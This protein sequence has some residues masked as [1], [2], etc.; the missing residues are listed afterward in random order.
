MVKRLRFCWTVVKRLVLIGTLLLMALAFWLHAGERSLNFA[1]P[2]IERA[3]NNPSAPYSISIGTVSVDWHNVAA[4]GKLRI[5][6][7]SF[8]KRDGSIFAKL[9]E[10]YATIDPIGFMPTRHLLHKVILRQ[11]SLYLVRN[12]DGVL[13]LGIENSPTRM[14]AAELESFLM[15]NDTPGDAKPMSLP[16]HDFIIEHANLTFSDEI[17]GTKIISSP[18]DFRLSRRR[19]SF[20]AVMAMP[21]TV[22]AVPVKLS[23]GL[24]ILPNS[25]S[26]VLSVQ[27]NGFPTKLICLFGVCDAGLNLDAAIS[28]NLAV[29]LA[30]DFS[31]HGFKASLVTNR[32]TLTAPTWFEQ[33]LALGKSDLT[34]EGDWAQQTFTVSQAN[35]TLEDTTIQ[36][37]ANAHKAE[38]GWYATLNGQTQK[39]DVTKLYKYWPLTMAPGSRTWVTSKMKS[40]YAAKGTLR[41]N[42]TPAEFAAEHFSDEAV[43]AMVDARQITFEYLPGFPLVERIDGIAHFTGT[44][45]KVEST[46]GSLLSGTTIN[47]AV[48]WVPDLNDP[49]IPMETTTQLTAPAAD[50][51]TML[52]LKHFPFDDALGLDPKAISGNVNATMKLKFNA[53]SGKPNSD[54]NEIHLDAVDYDIAASLTNVAQQRLYGSYDARDINAELNASNAGFEVKG[55]LVVGESG[56]HDFTLAQKSGDVLKATVKGRANPAPAAPAAVN[57]FSLVYE[58]GVVPTITVRGKRID[59]SMSYGKSENSLLANFPAMKLD[60]DVGELV[61]SSIESF[62]EVAGTLYCTAERCETADFTAKTD[63]GEVKATIGSLN[64]VRRFLLSA[65]DAGS[66]LKALDISE[67]MSKGVLELRGTYDDKKTPPQFNGRLIIKDF[68]LKN[69]QILGRILSI[70]SLT[71]LS[72]ALTGDGISFE[73][74]AATIQAQSGV[75]SLSKGAAN[76]NALGITVEGS[77]DT[78]TTKLALK[79]VVVPAYALN[80]ILGKIPIIG[81]IAGG[82]GEGLIAFNYSVKSTYSEPDVGVNP[83][84]GLTPGFLRGIFNVFDDKGGETWDKKPISNK[85][86]G[87]NQPSNVQKR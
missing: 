27:L 63:K 8:A 39:L 45:V 13:E 28:G 4:L 42:L 44:T 83:L 30:R 73:K 75:V 34:I 5:S 61:L 40:G 6:N 79:G 53:F 46:N 14:A 18:F 21:F 71:G 1:K 26:H 9:P 37:S 32:A 80:S 57:D 64:G 16:F 43:D 68:T 86:L 31:A 41:L 72:N 11:P 10:I 76:G 59:A 56:I 62:R 85:P 7:V 36:A 22:D 35:V 87:E 55:A 50:A 15:G 84:S 70:G 78:N 69:S 38:D 23:A 82:E 67:R 47:K 19:G 33:P 74:M 52:A 58:S 17:S 2:W 54:P 20:E 66:F 65:S 51:A 60:V 25:D 81:M 24:R 12:T 48:L 3:I 29:G 49:H 77:V